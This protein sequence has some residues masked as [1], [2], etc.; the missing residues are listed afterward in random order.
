MKK[1]IS[2]A[3]VALAAAGA[4]AAVGNM[5]GN[6]SQNEGL[7]AVPAKAAPVIDGTFA[8]GEWDFSGRIWS[9]AD[10][11]VKDQFSVKTACMWDRDYLYMAFDWRDPLP[12][13]SKVNPLDDPSHGWTADA[14]QLRVKT[15]R[16]LA[17]I[18]MWGYDGGRRPAFDIVLAGNGQNFERGG[19]TK[20]ADIHKFLYPNKPGV[21]DL[22][23]GVQLA[24]RMAEDGKGFTQ[25]L[26]MPWTLLYNEEE[27]VAKAE[28]VFRMGV[29]FYWAGPTGCGM[30][31][32]SYKDNLQPGVTERMFFWTATKVW[33]D[34]KLESGPVAERVYTPQTQKPVG[35]IKVRARV[36]ADREFFTVAIDDADGNRVRNL[37]GGCRVADFKVGEKDGLALVEVDWDGCDDLGRIV[38]P[39]AYRTRTLGSDR[40]DGYYEMCFYDPGTP[41]WYTADTKG[42]WGADHCPVSCLG[43]A[44]DAV[45]CCSAFAEGGYGTFAL[46][47]DGRKLWSDKRG[48]AVAAGDAKYTFIIPSDWANTGTQICRIDTATGKY[49]PFS[50]DGEMPFPLAKLFGLRVGAQPPR[51]LGLARV[52]AGLLILSDDNALR[53]MDPE[54]GAILKTIPLHATLF[55]ARLFAGLTASDRGNCPFAAHGDSVYTFFGRELRRTDLV[56]GKTEFVPLSGGGSGHTPPVEHPLAMAVDGKGE[57]YVTDGGQDSQVKVFSPDGRLLRRIGKTGGRNR[58]GPFDRSGV[59]EPKGLAIDA[60]GQVWV[61]EAQ[62]YP[63]RISVWTRDGDFVKDYLGNLKYSG[64]GGLIHRTDHT[65]AAANCNEIRLDPKTGEWDVVNIMY[66][67]DESKGYVI[68]PGGSHFHSGDLHYSSAS[69][70]RH[71]YFSSLGR[72]SSESCFFL[73]MREGYRWVPVA[74]IAGVGAIQHLRG[75]EHGRAVVNAPYGEWAGHDAADVVLWN[76]FNNDGYIQQDECEFVPAVRDT[77]PKGGRFVGYDWSQGFA[78]VDNCELDTEDLGFHCYFRKNS[79]NRAD[80][81]YGRMVPVRYRDGGKPVYSFKDGFKPLKNPG[82]SLTSEANGVY[83]VPGKDLNVGFISM[84][85]AVWVAGWKKSTEEILWKY[86]SPY[87]SVHGSHKAPMPKPGMLIGSLKIM[88]VVTD[89]GDKDVMMIR[90]NLGEDYFLTTDGLYVNRFTKDERIPGLIPPEDEE[91]YKKVSYA[92]LDGFGEHFSGI[93]CRQDDGVIRSTSSIGTKEGCSLVRMEGLGSLKSGASDEFSVDEKT[94]VVA[95]GANAARALAGAK[96]ASPLVVGRDLAKAKAYAVGSEGQRVKADFRA[97]YDAE[98]LRLRWTVKGDDSPWKNN[99]KD[100]RLLFK[101]GDC[102][103]FQLSPSGSRKS[104]P[105]EGDFRLLVA[106]FRGEPVAVKMQQVAKG[107]PP[108]RAYVYNSPVTDLRFDSVTRLAAKPKVLVKGATVEVELDVAWSDL[109]VAA[110]EAGSK[111]TGDVGFILSDPNGEIN[112]ARVYRSNKNTGLCKDQPNEARLEPAGYSEIA[113]E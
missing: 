40:I 19:A 99:G 11:D 42:A 30:P 4:L 37:A 36:P 23:E 28:D 51:V 65:K 97:A 16:S 14:V 18:T 74:G 75:G 33:G 73:M 70:E 62:D 76:D 81:R 32:H 47:P 46:G 9:F 80:T 66:N 43:A 57:I 90:G 54:S 15:S 55:G 96:P 24:Y 1:A 53:V 52:P 89:C 61:A 84:S 86:P 56:S 20:V 60:S 35:T 92:T 109:G 44:G 2:T 29:E 5:I 108:D 79:Q 101:T 22:G 103:D 77:T 6:Q 105:A 12:L 21:A 48:S 95:E 71:E 113:F 45:I 67:P 27:H 83:K 41:P 94:L 68:R 111:M 3:A 50:K 17:W 91:L 104:P 25:E 10:W 8:P 39:G 110:P 98:M 34:V 82:L 31:Y 69:G 7:S 63:R 13:N 87:H 26:R 49:V 102:V 107:A 106:N 72:F 88:G 112:T 78:V 58:Q 38:A 59:L 100:W 64:I 85:N 93:F